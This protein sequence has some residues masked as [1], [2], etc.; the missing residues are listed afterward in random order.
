MKREVVRRWAPG[1]PE[2][3]RCRRPR[4]DLLDEVEVQ[5]G[6]FE[7]HKGP[8]VAYERT[9][10]LADDGHVDERVRFELHLPLFGAAFGAFAARAF[11][12]HEHDRRRPL[13]APPDVLT[14]AQVRLLGLL[15]AAALSAT[16][17]N[18]LFTQTANFVAETFGVSESGQGRAGVIVRL[19]VIIAIPVATLADRVGR[20]RMTVAAAWATPLVCALGAFAPSWGV[21]VA[22]QAVG[23][24][25]GLALAVLIGVI[26]AEEMPRNSRAYSLSMLAL[27]GGLGASVAVLPLVLADIVPQGWRL[28]YLLALVFLPVSVMLGRALPETHRYEAHVEERAETGYHVPSLRWGRFGIIA[29]VAVLANLFVAPASFFQ[30]RYLNEVRDLSGF[31]IALFSVATATPA[32]VFLLIGGRVAD[33]V[34]RRL[35]LLIF[36]PLSTLALIASFQWGGLTMWLT[37]IV[38]AM[39]GALAYPAFTVYRAELFPTSNRGRV[40]GWLTAISLAGSSVGLLVAGELLDNGWTY[41]QVMGMLGLGQLAAA[42]IAFAFYPETAHLELEAINPEDRHAATLL[43]RSEGSDDAQIGQ[44]P[45]D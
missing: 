42:L 7:Q 36:L 40:N 13:W 24:P 41:G 31:G 3:E 30:N 20:R 19:G 25:L 37:T 6:R 38:G 2:A 23:R 10:R 15:A 12:R 17:A 27:A 26:V 45:G 11:G 18:T 33:G 16:F 39:A 22:T 34:G 29:L 43:A 28:I 9:I 4:A 44:P 5:P 8:F 32:A 35:V 14:A 21:L 1:S